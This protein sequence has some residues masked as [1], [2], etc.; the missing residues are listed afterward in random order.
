MLKIRII[1]FSVCVAAFISKTASAQFDTLDYANE[2]KNLF[3][4]ENASFLCGV[5][6]PAVSSAEFFLNGFN[7]GFKNYYE[8]NGSLNFGFKVRSL[9]RFSDRVSAYGE[10]SYEDFNTKSATGSVFFSPQETPFDILEQADTNAGKKKSEVYKITGAVSAKVWKK[11]SAGARFCYTAANYAKLKDLRCQNSLMDLT[12][13]IGIDYDFGVIKPGANYFYRR[14]NESLLF[15]THGTA[16]RNYNSI[17]SYGCF[18]GLREEFG[19]A[20]FTN[21]AKQIPLFDD[22]F[23]G[24]LQF[25]TRITDNLKFFCETS[26]Q[27]RTGSYGKKSQYTT[28]F[29][30]HNGKNLS[31]NGSLFFKVK[32][33]QHALAYGLKYSKTDCYM[34]I[35]LTRTFDGGLSDYVYY[36]KTKISGKEYKALNIRYQC[37]FSGSKKS[38]FK[39]E[40]GTEFFGRNSYA[41]KYPFWRKQYLKSREF[42]ASIQNTR[43]LSSEKEVVFSL[44]FSMKKGSG[45]PYTDGI[46]TKNETL[47]EFPATQEKFL[48]QEYEFLCK[49]QIK[50]ASGVKFSQKIF[51]G[52]IK[53]FISANS[54][55]T[56]AKNTNFSNGKRL[57]T[58][59][60]TGAIF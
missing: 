1:I 6:I 21:G 17:I 59:I 50:A 45:K 33:I 27:K 49:P 4:T 48:I 26:L 52:R 11:L 22:Y 56:R 23:G 40:T 20:G 10:I 44:G 36:G 9:Y 42:F 14:R 18:L 24:G 19:D 47:N 37:I 43:T 28:E 54:Q 55:I 41:V 30:T 51:S 32:N 16:D 34:N 13:T 46:F 53:G 29:T 25:L 38:V 5:N 7:G 8:G 39:T 31:S 3:L 12:C 58:E 57:F 2:E 15:S 60:K 35:Y